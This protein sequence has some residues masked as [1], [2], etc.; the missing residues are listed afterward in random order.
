MKESDNTPS[1]FGEYLKYLRKQRGLTLIEMQ[2]Q[3][4]VSNSYLSQLENGQFKPSPE[5]LRK[6]HRPL[7]VSYNTLMHK[8]GYILSENPFDSIT[9]VEEDQMHLFLERLQSIEEWKRRLYPDIKE[10]LKEPDV[11]FDKKLLNEENKKLAIKILD[12]LF[13]NLKVSYP[14]DKEIEKEYDMW[15]KLAEDNRNNN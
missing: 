5:I 12:V 14:S 7:S 9:P 1:E 10:I 2:E 15:E 6:L 13:E 11:Y 3:S 4:G 8:A